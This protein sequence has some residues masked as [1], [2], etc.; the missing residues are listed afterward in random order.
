MSVRKVYKVIVNG[1][2]VFSGS[3]KVAND[4]YN[5]FFYYRAEHPDFPFEIAM[6]FNPVPSV[7]SSVLDSVLEVN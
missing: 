6:S 3:Y 7:P 1:T 2:S 4:V 5:A